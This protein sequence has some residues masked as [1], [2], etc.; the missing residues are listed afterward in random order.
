MQNIIFARG[1]AACATITLEHRPSDALL[2][3]LR[4]QEM[5]LAVDLRA[6]GAQA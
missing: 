5:I 6:T 3:R 1:E 4:A 2:D